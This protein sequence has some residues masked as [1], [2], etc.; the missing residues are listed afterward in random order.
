MH[1]VHYH[2]EDKHAKG[3]TLEYLLTS[4]FCSS[5]GM[6]A[7]RDSCFVMAAVK[8]DKRLTAAS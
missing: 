1:S 2:G 3:F 4:R 5:A 6:H 8:Y 7:S